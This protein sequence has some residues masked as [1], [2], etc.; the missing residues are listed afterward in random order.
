LSHDA[1]RRGRNV[2]KH[3][4]RSLGGPATPRSADYSRTK[5]DGRTE[6]AEVAALAVVAVVVAGWPAAASSA[7]FGDGRHRR[8]RRRRCRRRRVALTPR[9]RKS[10]GLVD[11]THSYVVLVFRLSADMRGNVKRDRLDRFARASCEEHD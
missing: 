9:T 11:P 3:A 1:E 6:E 7:V 8:R 4:S 10:R 2:R 5:T